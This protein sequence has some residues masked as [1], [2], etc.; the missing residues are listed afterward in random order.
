MHIVYKVK[1]SDGSGKLISLFRTEHGFLV[2]ADAMIKVRHASPR[3]RSRFITVSQP[4][5]LVDDP[6]MISIEF[7]VYEEPNHQLYR[8]VSIT[9]QVEDLECSSEREGGEGFYNTAKYHNT[10]IQ[11]AYKLRK[12]TSL[13]V[14]VA[15][16]LA[17][18]AG[19]DPAHIFWNYG[20]FKVK[21]RELDM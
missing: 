13:D 6:H 16:V 2:L 17:I 8:V 15:K 5:V 10:V 1:E 21:K 18:F 4:P 12:W 14:T 3:H 7:R 9:T 11:T 19:R 20:K